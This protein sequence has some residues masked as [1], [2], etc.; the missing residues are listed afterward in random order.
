MTK[1]APVMVGVPARKSLEPW[2]RDEITYYPHQIDGVRTLSKW[3]NFLCADD[4]GLGKSLEAITVFA[5]DVCKGW[6]STAII[7][8]PVTLKQNWGDELEKFTRFPFVVL[9]G[10]PTVRI[11]QL[12][13]FQLIDG[14][15]V[16]IVNYEQVIAHAGLLNAIA[17]DIAIFDEAH[18]LKNPKAKRTKACLTLFSKRS[19][20][21]TGTPMLNHVN[22]LWP[23]LHRIDPLRWPNYYQFVNRFAVFGGWKNKQIIGVKNEKELTEKLQAYML[24]RI[25]SEVLDLPD[26]QYIERR[27]DLSPEQRKLYNQMIDEMTHPMIDSADEKEIENV[28]TRFLRLKQVCGTTYP[29]TGIDVSTK[30]DL[31]VEDCMELVNN[32]HRVVVFTQF[33]D[34]LSCFADRLP[35]TIPVFKLHGDVAAD[36]RQTVVK[37]WSGTSKAGVIVCMLQVAGVGLNMV[38]SRHALFLDK[39]FVPGLNRQAVDRIHRIGQDTTQQ[40]QVFEYVCRNTIENRIN[41]ILRTKTKL[42]GDIV[43]SDPDWKRKLLKAILEEEEEDAA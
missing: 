21:L 3:K 9:D 35:D 36:E 17:F 40:V 33:R 29:F 20:L 12:R 5:I 22:E 18:Y 24:R 43:E 15:K 30:L 16:L 26:V 8:C 2:I 23:L 1:P 25:K 19:F 4:M 13:E 10:T 11:Q 38:A 37:E 34:V 6:Y 14:P 28:L 39:L 7:V 32:G 31:A 42:F 41:A 27:V